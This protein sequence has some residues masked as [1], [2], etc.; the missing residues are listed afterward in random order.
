MALNL[1]EEKLNKYSASLLKV[2]DYINKYNR[3]KSYDQADYKGHKS[4]IDLQKKVRAGSFI[5]KVQLKFIYAYFYFAPLNARTSYGIK[6]DVLSGGVAFLLSALVEMIDK[7]S[8]KELQQFRDDAANTLIQLSMT[9]NESLS[10]GVYFDYFSFGLVPANT[11]VGY[12]TCMAADALL[13]L[14]NQTKEPRLIEI[15][16]KSCN[17]FLNELHIQEYT[18]DAV[19]LSYTKLDRTMVINTN[20]LTASLLYDFYSINPDESYIELG[21]KLLNFIIAMQNPDGSW[22]Y[23]KDD[24]HQIDH[25][26]TAM[27]LQAL[28]RVYKTN[29]LEPETQQK[30]LKAIKDGILFHLDN[31]FINNAPKINTTSHYPLGTVLFMEDAITFDLL[32]DISSD[33]ESELIN[34][35]NSQWLELIDY[36]ISRLQNSD[37]SFTAIYYP[38]FNNRFSMLR[39]SNAPMLRALNLTI[40]RFSNR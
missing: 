2:F 4:I 38:F 25:Y 6:P 26:H 32:N 28:I 22:Y 23:A 36:A 8:S 9:C 16:K 11:P 17:F 12:S 24:Y 27:T 39:W 19:A 21:N 3:F 40:K 5:S 29:R 33:L 13:S 35:V 30:V 10:W 31:L 15:L 37:G 18:K 20:A 7:D 34:R 1:T 14:Y